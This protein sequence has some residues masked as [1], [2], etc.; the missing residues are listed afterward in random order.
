[1]TMQ[2]QQ[3]DFM[4]KW[5]QNFNFTYSACLIH[6]RAIVVPLR[7]A[8]G[9]Q[10]LGVPCALALVVMVLW[11]VFSRDPLM[12]GWIA[13]WLTSFVGRRAE[14]LWLWAVGAKLH[15]WYDGY[16]VG[17]IVLGRTE[18][19]TKLL[20]EP[21]LAGGL[22]V[23]VYWWYDRCHFS[24]YGLPYFLLSG[25]FTLPFVEI[26][27]QK[28]WEHRTQSMVDARVE[29]EALMNDFRNRYGN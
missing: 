7:M 24:P 6:Q 1:M 3:D 11:A 22:G 18:K 29:Q 27:K 26:V 13:L 25:V 5:K 19:A 9:P 17:T 23:A 15:G 16:P 4:T 10:A 21:L 28:I 14:S 8:W 20:V 12:W 2:Q